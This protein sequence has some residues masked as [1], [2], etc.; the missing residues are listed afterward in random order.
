MKL[1][2]KREFLGFP[3]TCSKRVF[4]HDVDHYN[5]Q[6]LLLRQSTYML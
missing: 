4:I 6:T 3:F 2:T 1:V 5:T